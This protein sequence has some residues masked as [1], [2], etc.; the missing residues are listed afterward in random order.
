MVSTADSSVKN[1][2]RAEGEVC[3]SVRERLKKLTDLY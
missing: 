2:F 1:A 3:S